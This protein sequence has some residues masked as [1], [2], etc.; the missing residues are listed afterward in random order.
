M[1]FI[2]PAP[3]NLTGSAPTYYMDWQASSTNYGMTQA[4][5]EALVGGVLTDSRGWQRVGL[6]ARHVPGVAPVLFRVVDGATLPSYAVGLTTWNV[7]PILV[8][9]SYQRIQEGYGHNLVNHESGHAYFYASHEVGPGGPGIMN[10]GLYA[11]D[12]GGW[13]TDGDIADVEDWLGNIDSGGT[14]GGTLWFPGDIPYYFTDWSLGGASEARLN[15]SILGG[16]TGSS[17]KAVWANSRDDMVNG[18]HDEF[19]PPVATASPGYFTSGWQAI[20]DG[21]SGD[22]VVGIKVRK[23]TNSTDLAGLVV[24]L[25]EVQ[26][27]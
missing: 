5:V 27:R 14:S 16:A 22:V 6:T 4:E 11:A 17:L 12:T 15:L 21:P 24:G 13:P 26:I 10:T 23:A 19:T 9:I 20:P 25:A 18:R 2:R 8:Q 3:G 1:E 7:T